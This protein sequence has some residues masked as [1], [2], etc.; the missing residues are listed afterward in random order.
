MK[1][2]YLIT[3][4]EDVSALHGVRFV[5]S[6]LM[7]KQNVDLTLLY[8]A[9][10]SEMAGKP[11]PLH[12][13]PVEAKLTGPQA[14]KGKAALDSAR[15]LLESKGFAP[16]AITTKLRSKH[17]GT[18]KDIAVEA[19]KGHYDAVV[20]GRRGYAL[21]ERTLATS[22]SREMME[23]RIDFPIWVCRHPEEGRRDV[24]LCVED[25]EPCLRVAD[26][27][28]FILEKEP[29]HSVTLLHVDET[30]SEHVS[31]IMDRARQQL[32]ENHVD[33]ARI[34]EVLIRSQR[35]VPAIL[36]EVERGRYAAVAVGRG[37]KAKKGLIEK[38]LI[39]SISMKLLEV[40]DKATLWVSK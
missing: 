15:R 3:I 36:D 19:R 17:S 18:V 34:R 16:E 9:T 29:E 13:F 40:L 8:V 25:S 38:W 39:G 28:G 32:L 26:H 4:G 10:S 14:E 33:E 7:N 1:H 23:H 20:L 11:A 12:P 21:F 27:V 6:F 35:V 30:G 24:L 2:H 31:E 22:V 37:G 5:S